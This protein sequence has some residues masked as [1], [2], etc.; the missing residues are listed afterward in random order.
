MASKKKPKSKELDYEL[1]GLLCKFGNVTVGPE[2][3]VVG[4][5]VERQE[6]M[7]PQLEAA[8]V[9]AR[10]EVALVHDPA[11]KGD[12]AGQTKFV[13]TAKAR[14]ESV[15][16]CPSLSVRPG[17]FAFRLSF[18]VGAVDVKEF[19]TIAQKTGRVSLTRIGDSGGDQDEDD[20]G[21]NA[22]E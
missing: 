11:D 3:C 12:V 22:E 9:G 16:D 19:A 15:A 5:T 2:K 21:D 14:I 4:V 20:G 1:A 18:S 6:I 8:V 17:K 10:M 7:L 13:D